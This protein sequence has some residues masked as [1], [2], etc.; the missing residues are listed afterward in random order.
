MRQLLLLLLLRLLLALL[1]FAA[2]APKGSR[3][4]RHGR[5]VVQRGRR[6]GDRR[7]RGH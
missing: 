2:D 3:R 1:W 7:G 4:W 6:R 5:R